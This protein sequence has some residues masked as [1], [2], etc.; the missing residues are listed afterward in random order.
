MRYLSILLFAVSAPVYAKCPDWIE[1]EVFPPFYEE[2]YDDYGKAFNAFYDMR[3]KYPDI[4]VGTIVVISVKDI[5]H[6][7]IDFFDGVSTGYFQHCPR[8]HNKDEPACVTYQ[9]LGK[10][11]ELVREAILCANTSDHRSHEQTRKQP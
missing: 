11:Y 3:R 8:K 2:L 7:W 9:P 10:S 6:A 5:T 1:V 4:A